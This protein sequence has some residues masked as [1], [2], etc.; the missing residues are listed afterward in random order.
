MTTELRSS[1]IDR[2]MIRGRGRGPFSNEVFQPLLITP[3]ANN[4]RTPGTIA[5]RAKFAFIRNEAR[6]AFN[7][8][9]LA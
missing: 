2:R 5:E 6:Q 7:W 9:A 3:E 8:S 4:F 1:L